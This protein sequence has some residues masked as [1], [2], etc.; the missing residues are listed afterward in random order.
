[1][2]NI[3]KLNKRVTKR[4]L[5]LFCGKISNIKMDHQK[6]EKQ[7]TNQSESPVEDCKKM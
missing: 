6:K 7:D 5:I 2:T 4:D 3:K 1:M